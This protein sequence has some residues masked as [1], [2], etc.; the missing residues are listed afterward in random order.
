MTRPDFEEFAED[1][2]YN[3]EHSV[4]SVMAILEQIYELG[5]A[6]GHSYED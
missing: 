1:I 3:D 4:S 2:M 5:W 6:D